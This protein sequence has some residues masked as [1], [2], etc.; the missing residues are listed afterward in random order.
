M[1]SH[2]NQNNISSHQMPGGSAEWEMYGEV[3]ADSQQYKLW[4]LAFWR[5]KMQN[6]K[7]DALWGLDSKAKLALSLTSVTSSA[8]TPEFPVS[9]I[10]T[11]LLVLGTNGPFLMG[12]QHKRMLVILGSAVK[13]H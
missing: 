12:H 2:E 10:E 8:R 11:N 5:L 13:V 9:G 3:E 7:S 4:F 1:A 6:L